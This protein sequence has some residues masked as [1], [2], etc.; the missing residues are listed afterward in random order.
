MPAAIAWDVSAETSA[1]SRAGMRPAG[2]DRF[3]ADPDEFSY[4]TDLS[5]RETRLRGLRCLPARDAP[6]RPAWPRPAGIPAYVAHANSPSAQGI[7]EKTGGLQRY[8]PRHTLIS[9][10]T[11][12]ISRTWPANRR[13]PRATLR[14]KTPGEADKPIK[15]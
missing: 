3:A 14:F 1:P 6:S 5:P 11:C 12:A 8:I 9:L 2:D 4:Q 13:Q 10:I 7:N 15:E